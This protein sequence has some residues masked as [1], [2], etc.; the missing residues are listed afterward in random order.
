MANKKFTNEQRA[1]AHEVLAYWLRFNN[2]EQDMWVGQDNPVIEHRVLDGKTYDVCD[3]TM[4]AAGTAVFLTSPTE[5]F[6][7]AARDW[8]FNTWTDEGG[9]RLGLDRTEATAVF[10]SDEKSAKR[11]M[12]AI[13]DGSQKA[14]DK[15]LA[16]RVDM[17]EQ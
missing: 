12:R 14:W 6:R 17:D 13:A 15:A 1:L 3:T 5:V 8:N 9:K 4:C 7:E 11:F 2:H 16:K 10:T